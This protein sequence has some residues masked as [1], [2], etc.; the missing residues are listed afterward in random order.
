MSGIQKARSQ[1]REEVK[2][3][4]E[5]R[6]GLLSPCWG[7]R[8][9]ALFLHINASALPLS[10]HQSKAFPFDAYYNEN[11]IMLQKVEPE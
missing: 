1:T 9:S 8:G 7:S 11:E 10:K 4:E 5:I 2:S 6:V 3:H